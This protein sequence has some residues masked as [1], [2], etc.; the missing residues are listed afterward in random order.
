[1]FIVQPAETHDMNIEMKQED[2]LF[3]TYIIGHYNRTVRIY[4][5]VSLDLLSI[6]ICNLVLQYMARQ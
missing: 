1:M 3:T 6:A 4:D 2:V 5:L